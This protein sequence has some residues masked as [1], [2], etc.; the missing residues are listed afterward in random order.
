MRKRKPY[1]KK[2]E[3]IL[4]TSCSDEELHFRVM[5]LS[6]RSMYY[7]AKRIEGITS[8]ELGILKKYSEDAENCLSRIYT[9]MKRSGLCEEQ[10]K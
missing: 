7:Y 5:Q 3:G 2:M 1:G 4:T 8:D 9:A 6:I 10:K